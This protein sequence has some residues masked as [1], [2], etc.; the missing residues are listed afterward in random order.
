MTELNLPPWPELEFTTQD[1]EED[2]FLNLALS[3]L[4]RH[5]L[6]CFLDTAG[7][8]GPRARKSILSGQ[9]VA[10]F[11]QYRNHW[12]YQDLITGAMKHLDAE[13]FSNWLE[14]FHCQNHRPGGPMLFPM[15]TYE[16]FNP[17]AHPDHPHPLWR[18]A[19]G[20]WFLT[21]SAH[22]FDRERNQLI[23]GNLKNPLPTPTWTN[24]A[25]GHLNMGWREDEEDYHGKI[26][27]VQRDIYDGIY[28][29]A[30]LSQRFLSKS[31][32]T[33]LATY[34][35]LRQL[36]PSP[37]MGVF[38]LQNLWVLSGSPER[39]AAKKDQ[40]ITA[41]PIAGTKPR[42]TNDPVRDAL[43]QKD[44]VESPKERAEHL[45][46]VDLIR[47]DLGR[48]GKPGS[49]FVEEFCTVETYSHVHHLVSQVNASL[50]EKATL[51]D[52]IEAVFP[53]GTITG[54]PKISCIK[55]LSELEK[56]A[57]GPYTG[58]MGYIDSNGSMDM[59]I[60]IR[61]L[62]QYED[63]VCFHG[64]GGI[65]ADSLSSSEYQ[66]TRQKCRALMEALNI[67]C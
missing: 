62:I 31:V 22:I 57:R 32:Q 66:E 54:A 36:N 49:V 21:A 7:P 11:L 5:P 19:D 13:T 55:R 44:L 17:F 43:S 23:S 16:A 38:R 39:L 52:F 14:A 26:S 37:F 33:P 27:L 29:Q 35:R 48:V 30:N 51:V 34:R 24:H 58:S 67:N 60:L 47:N 25:P 65:V 12:E 18:E 64:G 41:R 2:V 42:F 53:G 40:A 15:L 63:R 61:T 20:I 59:N 9:P 56:E 28:Y 3:H 46:L 6:S 4:E 8:I 50:K 45:M 10:I 1:M